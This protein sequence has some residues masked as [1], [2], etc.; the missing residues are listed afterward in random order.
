MSRSRAK[1]AI[2]GA[3]MLAAG[4]FYFY[5][6]AGL[7]RRGTVDAA[8]VPYVLASMMI[9]L[10][11]LQTIVSLRAGSRDI[12]GKN[13]VSELPGEADPSDRPSYV[14]VIKTL[15]LIAGF[16]ALLRPLGFPVAAALYLFLQ[17]L[18][19]TPADNKPRYGFYALLAVAAALIIFVSFR[20]GFDL[21]LPAGPFTPYLP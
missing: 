19:L 15:L 4:L 14:T 13:E 18:V 8:F 2:V 3:C 11:L 16:T 1:P 6:V 21:I 12:A 5:L 10:G 9:G 7:P 17:F 20:Y